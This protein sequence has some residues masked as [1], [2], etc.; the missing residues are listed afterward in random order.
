MFKKCMFSIYRNKKRLNIYDTLGG[1]Y[2]FLHC[3]EKA[4][5]KRVCKS[6]VSKIKSLYMF[7]FLQLLHVNDSNDGV[8]NGEK[9]MIFFYL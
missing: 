3:I 4:K 2:F 5:D 7:L 1:T 6:G 8:W 9:P